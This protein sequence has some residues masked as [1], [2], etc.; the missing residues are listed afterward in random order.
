MVSEYA[1]RKLLL[2][3]FSPL[4]GRRYLRCLLL[5]SP[6][7]SQRSLSFAWLCVCNTFIALYSCSPSMTE[8]QH[9]IFILLFF[10]EIWLF[11][12][13]S[14]IFSSVF[15]V[16][17]ASIFK[18]CAAYTCLYWGRFFFLNRYH[19]WQANHLVH[20]QIVTGDSMSFL[21]QLPMLYTLPVLSSWL[22]LFQGRRWAMLCWMLCWRGMLAFWNGFLQYIIHN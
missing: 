13:F 20:F 9:V 15:Y 22:W 19:L 16:V 5:F 21:T 6:P 10:N 8:Y 7:L 3:I 2:F 14:I 4:G 17:Y 18:H 1:C 11:Y 12:L